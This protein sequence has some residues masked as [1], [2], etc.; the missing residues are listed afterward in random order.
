MKL[1]VKELV[2]LNWGMA[3]EKKGLQ[4][5]TI[6]LPWK[7]DETLCWIWFKLNIKVKIWFIG[8]TMSPTL[9]IKIVK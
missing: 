7:P 4:L 2:A 9:S 5:F 6:N 3:F 8:G 1:N